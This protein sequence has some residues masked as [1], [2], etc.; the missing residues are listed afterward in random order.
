LDAFS[1][2]SGDMT[3]SALLDLGVPFEIVERAV[4]SLSLDGVAV[5]IEAVDMGSI[6]ALRFHV[7]VDG[8]QR[9]RSYHDID[10]LI[11]QSALDPAAKGLARSIFEKLGAAE[12]DVHRI[13]IDEVHFHEVGASDAIVDIVAAA[14]CF[15]FIGAEV[16]CAPLPMGRGF[17]D[18]EHGRLPLPAPATVACLRGAPTYDAGIEAELVTPT[19]AAIVARVARSFAR[20]PTFAPERVGFGAGTKKLADRPNV[21]RAV[22]GDSA[23]SDA[24]DGEDTHVVVEANVDDMTGELAGHA[25]AALMRAGALD[26]WVT[27]VTMKKGRP[28]FV[29]SAL[30]RQADGSRL[31]EVVLRETSSIGV[32]WARVSRVERPRSV[33]T[34]QT[35]Y[36]DLPVKVS[37]GPFGAPVVKPEFDAC[38]EAAER[39]GVSVRTVVDAARGA[40]A[41]SEVVGR[42]R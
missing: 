10:T 18:A 41:A 21:L 42:N 20:W 33:R 31:S 4:E 3:V 23:R 36:G 13:P 35:P 16:V 9:H 7:D 6:G 38:R 2:I 25:I 5:R 12:A 39:H 30:A 17:V 26:A 8:P 37:S 15:S 14:A 34:V 24:R 22:L 11:G 29:L 32:R 40:A 1:G 28:G 19:G 27:P